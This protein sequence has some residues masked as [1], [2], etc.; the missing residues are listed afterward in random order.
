MTLAFQK[1]REAGEGPQAA[2]EKRSEAAK[3]QRIK[4]MDLAAAEAVRKNAP[5][6]TCPTMHKRRLLGIDGADA[7][8]GKGRADKSA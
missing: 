6:K 3:P 8:Q 4:D 2:E 1:Q 5:F 7:E